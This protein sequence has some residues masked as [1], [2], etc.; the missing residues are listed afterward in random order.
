[1]KQKWFPKVHSARHY[2]YHGLETGV[3][4]K[5]TIYPLV[6]YD[7]GQGAPS[8]INTNPEHASFAEYDQPNCHP[9]SRIDTIISSFRFSLTK[10]AIETDKIHR[11]R[12]AV[13]PIFTTH[14]T[15]LEAKDELT[16][17]EIEDILELQ[18]EITDRQC[19][20]LFNG[21]KVDEKATNSALLDASVPGLTTTQVLEGVTFTNNAYYDCLHYYTNKGMMKTVQGGMKWFQLSPHHNTMQFNYK[22][23]SKSKAM[24]PYQFAG[25]LIHV[26]PAG[27]ADQAYIASEVTNIPH[28]EVDVRTRFNEWNQGF[29]MDKI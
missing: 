18:H 15:E 2:W 5:A 20:P 14:L 8:T 3:N 16:G 21:V 11:L 23:R 13:M 19:Y 29:D 26:P 25:L 4:N 6:M 28:L 10:G 12:F 17:N 24:L 7:E 27:N 1:M 22:L 9:G